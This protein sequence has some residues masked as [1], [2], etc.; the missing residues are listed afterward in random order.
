MYNVF[1]AK[2]VGTGYLLLPFYIS[3][4]SLCP[5]SWGCLMYW[6]ED[7]RVRS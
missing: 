3:L 5:V 2:E 7:N 1:E 4:S 6:R